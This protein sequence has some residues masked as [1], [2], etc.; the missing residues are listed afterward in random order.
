[1]SP[2]SRSREYRG[3]D[4]APQTTR[5][6]RTGISAGTSRR[7][8]RV[9]NSATPDTPLHHLLQ[10]QRGD[11]EAAQ[12]EEDVDAEEARAGAGQPEVEGDHRRDRDEAQPVQSIVPRTFGLGAHV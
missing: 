9:Q 12:H 5:A 11:Q 1:M 2:R 7:A 10:Q 3:G 6:T 8:R 4:V